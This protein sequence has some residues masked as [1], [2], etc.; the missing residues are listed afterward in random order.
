MRGV[1]A[2]T[3]GV[4]ITLT[5][6]SSKCKKN[7]DR[8]RLRDSWVFFRAEIKGELAWLFGRVGTSL[9]AH[10]FERFHRTGDSFKRGA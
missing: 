5:D 8:T 6:S 7:G 4:K 1:N 9:K 3:P 10:S 2:R